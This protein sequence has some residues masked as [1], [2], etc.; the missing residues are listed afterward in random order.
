MQS[1]TF[2]IR[3][4]IQSLL[5]CLILTTI[6][7]WAQDETRKHVV[8]DLDNYYSLSLKYDVSVNDLKNANPGV[9]S[10]KPGDIL[11][12]P[13]KG[14]DDKEPGD[15]D[16]ARLKKMRHETI[17]V[18]LMIPLALEQVADTAWIES[19]SPPGISE[20]V[21]FR[22]IQFYHGFMIAADSLRE[23]GLDVEIHVYDVDQQAYKAINVLNDPDLKKMDII[24]GPFFKSTFSLVADFALQNKIYLVNPLTSRQD[25]VHGNPYVFKLQP[26]LESQPAIIAGIVKRDFPDYRV[27]FYTA[28][29]FQ[30]N[31]LIGK[32][33]QALGGEET[34]VKNKVF[35]V[36]YAADSIQG[37]IHH[38]S[39]V[40]P[41]LVIIYA[42]NEALPAALLGKLSAFK[43]DYRITVIG[44]PGWEKF[45]NI[46]LKYL[47]DL[48][49]NIIMS[50]YVDYDSEKIKAFIRAYRARYFD[51]PQNYAFS[52]FDA[53]YFFL[54]ALL[55]YGHDFEKCIN[56]TGTPLIQNQF[57]FER[58]E[59]GGYD[60][61]NWNI[62]QYYDYSLLRK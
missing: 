3:I 59:N 23:E 8:Q 22:F 62:L 48:N 56:D 34:T 45:G 13:L 15:K 7:L 61:I 47:I 38:S 35:F 55:F 53:G 26:S 52:G 42:D 2:K 25:I 5:F 32:F 33:R 57:H 30:D 18:A 31:E 6:T 36:D 21:P 20:V 9:T 40:E 28:N 50:S 4:F 60:N 39:K 10:P 19:L 12:I 24:F 29:K 49:A 44:L 46:E 14:A 43:K 41:N 58:V 54:R 27:I 17:R 1:K 51:E 11:I 37:F 16:C